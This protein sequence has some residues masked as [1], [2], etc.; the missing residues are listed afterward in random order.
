MID[1]SGVLD[2]HSAP[3]LAPGE[4]AIDLDHLSR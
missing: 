4:P 1:L 2:T 3:S